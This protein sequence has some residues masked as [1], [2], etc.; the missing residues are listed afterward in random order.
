[1]DVEDEAPFRLD[2][3][4][5]A[6][7][8]TFLNEAGLAGK[9][10]DGIISYSF[11]PLFGPWGLQLGKVDRLAGTC[12]FVLYIFIQVLGIVEDLELETT[13][14]NPVTEPLECEPQA[15][16]KTWI[17]SSYSQ[18]ERRVRG[19]EG[20]CWPYCEVEGVFQVRRF[21]NVAFLFPG[22]SLG[23]TNTCRAKEDPMQQR[24]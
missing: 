18:L 24:E 2:V 21:D 17:I 19:G 9:K 16:F 5:Q 3:R 11:D 15:C 4:S 1:M 13:S 14:V 23:L 6:N 8:P 22:L 10:E 12:P 7:G 20:P